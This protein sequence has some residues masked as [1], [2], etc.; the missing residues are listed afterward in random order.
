MMTM[1]MT[2]PKNQHQLL[3]LLL[4]ACVATTTSALGGAAKDDASQQ[5]QLRHASSSTELSNKNDKNR[6]LQF[7]DFGLDLGNLDLENFD[8][9]NFDLENFDF[10]NIDLQ[11]INWS[12]LF[13]PDLDLDN[14]CPIIEGI[15]G[16]GQAFGIA[17]DC[18]CDGTVQDGLTVGCAFEEECVEPWVCG[19]I[20]LNVTLGETAGSSI[21]ADVCVDVVG[22][23]PEICYGYSLSTAVDDTTPATQSCEATYDGHACICE[24]ENS[25]LLIN[26]GEFLP[27]AVMDTCQVVDHLATEVDASNLLPRFQVFDPNFQLGDFDIDWAALDWQN[28]DWRNFDLDTF[29]DNFDLNVENDDGVRNNTVAWTDIFGFDFDTVAICPA[30]EQL[31]GLGAAFG[32]AGGCACEGSLTEGLAIGCSFADQCVDDLPCATVGFNVSLGETP[33]AFFTDICVDVDDGTYPEICYGYDLSAV[34]GSDV[35]QSC[36]ATYGVDACR[37]Q[38]DENSCMLIDCSDYLDGAV[39]D[40]CQYLGTTQSEADA[41][42]FVPRFQVFDP[43]YQRDFGDLLDW[44]NIDWGNVDWQ[45]FDLDSLFNQTDFANAEWSDIFG[46][47]FDTTSVCPILEQFAGLGEEF[48][49]AGGCACD[50]SLTEGLGIDCTFADQCLITDPTMVCGSVDFKLS[51]GQTPGAY[52]TDICVDLTDGEYPEICYS[53]DLSLMDSTISQSCEAS[54]DGKACSCEIVDS[55]LTIDCT[56]YLPG[57][58]MDSCQYLGG[59]LQTGVDAANFLPRLQVLDPNF[60]LNFDE[61]NW[62]NLDWANLDW[63]NFDV[64]SLWNH[65][66]WANTEWNDIFDVDVDTSTICPVLEQFAGVGEEFGIAGG[67]ACSG[68][69]VSGLGLDCS[70]EEV[71]ADDDLCGSTSLTFGFDGLGS[72]SGEACVD[73]SE[74][75]HPTTCFSYAIPLADQMTAPTCAATYGG[76]ACICTIDEDFCVSIDCSDHDENAV[77]NTCSQVPT[78]WNTA[79]DASALV[80]RFSLATDDGETTDGT[81]QP[82]NGSVD[83]GETTDGTI[84]PGNGSVDNNPGSTDALNGSSGVGFA[85]SSLILTVLGIGS[86]ALLL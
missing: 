86:I 51:L 47:D 53:Y 6:K 24:I 31:A 79:E 38:I 82:G 17:G 18:Q 58:V 2:I 85:R 83:D 12:D 30:L 23:I 71:C 49:I 78:S 55:C 25:C 81:I 4:V 34:P 37:C 57:A 70:F 73:F 66:D 44:T 35:S 56:A 60:E 7:P 40:T 65:S 22:S 45:N 8:W 77:T 29:W 67:C 14:I 3:P 33:G 15:S 80:P 1:T 11:S 59:A 52:S 13:G 42:A 63:R 36:K 48:G 19:S 64:D 21:T 46:L 16:I 61:V 28:L 26:C 54:Y 50:G 69:S 41:A 39:M 27:G 32:I 74:D 20:G 84:Q 5:Q 43:N 68:D 10:G 75:Q 9:D 62:M 72:I 76:A